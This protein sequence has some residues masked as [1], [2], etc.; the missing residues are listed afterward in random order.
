MRVTEGVK[1]HRGTGGTL[2]G[3]VQGEVVVPAYSKKT[4]NA[5]HELSINSKT[6]IQ[7]SK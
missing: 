6:V 2:F 3:T 4:E 7:N 5:Q 1:S